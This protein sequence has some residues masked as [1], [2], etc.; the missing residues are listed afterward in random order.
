MLRQRLS[1]WFDPAFLLSPAGAYPGT[2]AS[3][4]FQ[5]S[6]CRC[7]VVTRCTHAAKYPDRPVV[8]QACC[9]SSAWSEGD[10]AE[11]LQD[12]LVEASTDAIELGAAGGQHMSANDIGG[13]K[14]TPSTTHA[15]TDAKFRPAGELGSSIDH[16]SRHD[17]APEGT[18]PGRIRTFDQGIMS[19]L[20]YR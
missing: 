17:T 2:F 19:P 14:T 7:G 15:S 20:L 12:G 4:S 8:R 6:T 5:S 9:R 10:L 13:G 11:L 3:G 16:V 18:G 1:V